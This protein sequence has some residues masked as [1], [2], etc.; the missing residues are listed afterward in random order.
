MAHP[1]W[2]ESGGFGRVAQVGPFEEMSK[3]WGSGGEVEVASED[4]RGVRSGLD[5]VGNLL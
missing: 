1:G 2:A 3:S 4:G 5:E